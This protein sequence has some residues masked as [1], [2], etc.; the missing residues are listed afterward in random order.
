LR[1]SRST[2]EVNLSRAVDHLRAAIRFG[3]RGK[4]VYFD[5]AVPDT[6][7]LVEGE[8]RKAFESLNRLGDSFFKKNPTIDRDRVGEIRQILTHDYADVDR[9]LVWNIVTKE[10]PKLLR[11]LLRAR[12]PREASD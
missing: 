11:I 7:L 4:A 12:L 1:T 6:F 8:L 10:A 5:E 3:T 2:N 9:K